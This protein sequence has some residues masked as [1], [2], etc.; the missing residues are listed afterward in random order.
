M[1][2]HWTPAPPQPLLA[3]Q[4]ASSLKI[5]PL[6]AQCLLNRGFSEA[7]S[8]EN[9]LEPRLKSLADPFLLPNMAAAIERLLL[10][11]LAFFHLAVRLDHKNEL[12]VLTLLQ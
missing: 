10:D 8:I 5:S 2:F 9:F 4:L 11:D 6:L 12:A 3:G 1:K 7:T